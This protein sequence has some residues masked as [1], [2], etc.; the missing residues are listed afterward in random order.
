[1]IIQPRD[2]LEKWLHADPQ[3]AMIG[4]TKII[5]ADN[6]VDQ[7]H[8]VPH[9]ATTSKKTGLLYNV[10]TSKKTGLYNVTTSKKTGLYNVT[11]WR[12]TGLYNVTNLRKTGWTIILCRAFEEYRLN[13][14]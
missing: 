6:L 5:T 8:D 13:D 2:L 1:M 14:D 10:T 3:G 7:L 11:N 4:G 12:K 9:I